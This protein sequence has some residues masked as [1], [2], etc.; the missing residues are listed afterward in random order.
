[1]QGD[2]VRGKPEKFADHYSQATLFWDSQ[3]PLE[4]AH[5]AA[6]FRFELGKLTV[7]AIQERM[8]ASLVNVSRDLAG[9]VAQGLG[10]KLPAALARALPRVP[11]P[12]VT[13][14]LALSLTA[15]P[16][17]GGIRTRKVAILVADGVL[18]ASVATVVQA[19]KAADAVPCIIAKQLGEVTTSDGTALQAT[20]TY[21]NSSPA[22]FD[23]M[24]LADGESGVAEMSQTQG[25]Q[26]FIH[27]H[28][29]HGKTLLV[30][31]LAEV[32]LEQAGI[33]IF[34][35]GGDLDPGMTLSNPQSLTQETANFIH[36]MGKHR[37]TERL[38]ALL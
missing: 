18:G 12:E 23:A 3:T 37:H 4:Q 7:P 31:G 26:D 22:L 13:H 10:M 30:L 11:K 24:V 1:M 16:G 34:L 27:S 19:L 8:V 28:Y 25:V 5:I 17:D 38:L 29:K 35:P 36:A 32:L 6:G 33:R 14:S 20:G 21:E 2:K 9:T 15:L